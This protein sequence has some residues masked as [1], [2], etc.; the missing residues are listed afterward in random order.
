M[1][2]CCSIFGNHLLS[3][4]FWKGSV[5]VMPSVLHQWENGAVFLAAF[6]ALA[7]GF[8]APLAPAVAAEP[9]TAIV[10]KAAAIATTRFICPPLPTAVGLPGG[11]P[12]PVR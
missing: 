7:A 1:L 5:H 3:S 11:N 10:T 12:L 4:P 2:T 9:K 6:N 8:A